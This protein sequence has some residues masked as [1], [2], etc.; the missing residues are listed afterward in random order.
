MRKLLSLF[1]P[2]LITWYCLAYSQWANAGLREYFKEDDGSTNWQ[3][4]AN[5]SSGILIIL[6]ST[7]AIF[8]FV[9]RRALNRSNRALTVMN[10]ELELRVQ[11]RTA[12]LDESNQKLQESNQRLHSS[13][14]YIKSILKSMPVMLAGLD[15]NGVVTHWN[16]AAERITGLKAED[17]LDQALWKVYPMIPVSKEQVEKAVSEQEVLHLRRTYRGQL[18]F[19]ITVYPLGDQVNGGVVILIDDVTQ[20]VQSENQLIE[21]DKLSAMGEL[22]SV[23]AHDLSAPLHVINEEIFQ[24]MQLLQVESKS[25]DQ[26]TSLLT[27]VGDQSRR[28]L[29]IT[30]NLMEFSAS[31]QD[32]LTPHLIPE[33]M[34][35]TLELAEEIYSFTDGL[36]LSDV[37]VE[38]KYEADLPLIPC[39]AS[40]LQQVFLSLIRHSLYAL[41]NVERPEHQAKITIQVLTCYDSLWVKIQHNGVGID[42]DEQQIIFEPYF[43]HDSLSSSDFDA[44]KRLSFPYFIITEHHQGHMAVTS[45]VNVGTTFH[46]ELQLKP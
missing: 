8:L 26:L 5:W 19:E 30:K 23:M 25:D 14:A 33:I 39:L 4:V 43:S 31:S 21:K 38:R 3:Y 32:D 11:E 7:T 36:K 22:S 28:A 45:D 29:A 2:A 9:S 17:A 15:Q 34:D 10:D 41:S 35:H 42:L 24:A 13:E 18:H 40:E 1:T 37:E 12:T 27:E 16:N 20:Q 6:L 44:S 46:I